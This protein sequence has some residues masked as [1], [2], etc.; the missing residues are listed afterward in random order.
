MWATLIIVEPPGFNEVLGLSERG[1]E[2]SEVRAGQADFQGEATEG[3]SDRDGGQRAWC[4]RQVSPWER[5]D[6]S[7]A[8]REKL[9]ARRAMTVQNRRSGKSCTELCGKIWRTLRHFLCFSSVIPKPFHHA[10]RGYLR[11]ASSFP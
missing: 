5:V 8:A 10:S 11:V 9:R 4:D 3:R 1:E 7:G 2:T 6:A